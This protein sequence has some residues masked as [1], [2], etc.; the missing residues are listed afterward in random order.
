MIKKTVLILGVIVLCFGCNDDPIDPII[1]L[2]KEL[3]TPILPE[4]VYEYETPQ[5]PSSFEVSV[6]TFLENTPADNPITNHG[7]TLGRVLFHDT[8]LSANDSISCASCHLQANAFSDPRALSEG[9][10]GGFTSRN[11]QAL[12]N[13]RY[14]R[15]MFW[16]GRV[17]SLEN[18][19]LIPVQ[20]S[21]EMGSELTALIEELEETEFYPNLFENAFGSTEINQDGMEKA[22]SQFLRSIISYQSKYDK[23]LEN[24]FADFSTEE[25]LGKT[26]FFNSKCNQCHFTVNFSNSTPLNNGLE[27]NYSDPGFGA[28][29]GNIEDYGKFKAPT[30]RNVSLSAPYMH[31]GRFNTLLEVIEHYNSGVKAHPY[32]DDRLTVESEIGGTPTQMNLTAAEKNALVAFLHTLTDESV[33]NDQRFSN[34]FE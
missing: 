16:D 19:A 14:G 21:L 9:F 1:D 12:I 30:L 24:D 11:A 15:R 13:L 5:L 10:N 33:V 2:P 26:I 20:D 3:P 29:S 27:I 25:N 28:I 6:M 22:I 23:G 7:A 8:R 17:N 4:V 32:L 31:D 34:P 18:L